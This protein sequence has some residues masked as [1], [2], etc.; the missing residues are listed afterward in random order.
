MGILYSLIESNTTDIPS[1]SGALTFNRGMNLAGGAVDEIIMRVT[2]VN[3]DNAILADF[4]N[5]LTSCRLILNGSTVTDFRSGYSSASN[6]A[7]SS[8]NYFLNSLGDSRMVEI[9]GSTAKDVMFRWPI[10]RNIP[11]GISRFEY[12]ISYAATA[13]A[14]ASGTI[15]W[16]VRYN[17]NFS[18]TTTI[19]SSTSFSHAASEETVVVRVPAGIP[20]TIAGVY[21]QND[22]AADELT[23]IRV[24]SQSDY[25][26]PVSMWRGFNGDSFNSLLYADDDV[27]TTQQT[28][29]IQSAGNLWIPLYGL[30]M[31]DDLRLQVNSSAVTVRTYT[32]VITAPVNARSEPQGKQTEALNIDVARTVVAKTED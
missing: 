11:A 12:T 18:T 30:T 2:L 27:S 13:A 9:P 24:I 6:N 17:D 14:V 7:C 31:N 25:S 15:E 20:G 29:A 1:A 4:G 8:A 26:L 32:P 21:V 5:V 3:T 28:V 16:W 19:G 22:S 10:G 23:G